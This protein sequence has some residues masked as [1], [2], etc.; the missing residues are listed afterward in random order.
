MLEIGFWT[1]ALWLLT[2]ADLNREFY[3]KQMLR[4][5]VISS[6]TPMVCDNL[7]SHDL[8]VVRV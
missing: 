1:W 6:V 4:L 5:G 2:K 7:W 3:L 8:L